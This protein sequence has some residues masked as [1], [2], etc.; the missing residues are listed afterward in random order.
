VVVAPCTKPPAAQGDSEG[1]ATSA[2]SAG[3]GQQYKYVLEPGTATGRWV[4]VA[5]GEAA[6]GQVRV[7]TSAEADALNKQ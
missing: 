1:P 2:D 6:A 7:M 4:P 5:E 3:A